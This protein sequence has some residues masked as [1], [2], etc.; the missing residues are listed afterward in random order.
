MKEK[1]KGQLLRVT[2]KQLRAL[3]AVVESGTIS[4]AARRLNLT[5]PAV[6]LQLRALE[7]AAGMPLVERGNDR[8]RLTDAGHEIL[9]TTKR[10]DFALSECEESL[11]VLGGV[12]RGRVSVGVVS[13]AKYFAPM[14]L[15][16]FQKAHPKVEIRQQVGNRETTLDALQEFELDFAI[17][18]RPPKKFAVDKAVIGDHPHIIIGPPDHPLAPRRRLVLSDLV[19][20]TFLLRE[21]GSGTRL[22]MQRLFSDAG[23]NPHVGMEIGSNETIKQAVMA[24]LGIAL[25]SAH[26]AAAELRDGRLIAFPVTGLPVVRQWFVIKMTEKRLLPAAHALWDFFAT[27]GADFLPDGSGLWHGKSRAS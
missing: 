22:L 18:G 9:K 3:A 11:A 26:T 27:A 25:I 15:A 12:E 7:D 8:L 24:G 4:A 6:S 14:V 20:E 2:L 23:L 13:T 21:Q 19:E 16:A 1:L 5:P 10:I 17:T